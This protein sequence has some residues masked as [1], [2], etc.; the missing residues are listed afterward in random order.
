MPSTRWLSHSHRWYAFS[1]GLSGATCYAHN[2][3]LVKQNLKK[4]HY[5]TQI[6]YNQF[7]L[8]ENYKKK[9]KLSTGLISLSVL[10]TFSVLPIF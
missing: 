3:Q 1:L 8:T 6:I 9:C 5:K 2:Y 4:I 10:V 7:L